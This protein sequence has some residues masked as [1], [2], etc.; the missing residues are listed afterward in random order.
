MNGQ[1]QLPPAALEQVAQELKRMSYRESDIH[2][3]YGENFLRV[4][5][6][7]WPAPATRNP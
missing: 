4:A 2:N 1:R 5:Q 6:S 7:T 3:I